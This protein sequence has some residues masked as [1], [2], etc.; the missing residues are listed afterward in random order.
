MNY[1]SKLENFAER[2]LHRNL[3]KIIVPDDDNGYIV[4]GE[5]YLTPGTQGFNVYT[6][7]DLAG[8]FTSKKTAL[9]YCVADHLKQYNLARTIKVLDNKKQQLLADIYCRQGQARRSTS[10]EFKE[11]VNTKL[12]TKMFRLESINQELEK[13]LN[14]AKYLQIRG[15]SNET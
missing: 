15:F 1:Q 5:Y 4:F 13:C 3:H 8:K 14:S 12:E 10:A 6:M 2:E 9:S 11:T 7:S